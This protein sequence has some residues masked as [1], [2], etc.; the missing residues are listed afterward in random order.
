VER[1]QVRAVF[2]GLVQGVCFR[3][4]V[5]DHAQSLQLV[6]WVRNCD[7]SSV[8]MLAQGT[9]EQLTSLIDL[10]QQKPGYGRVDAVQTSFGPIVD[11]LSN[12]T[13]HR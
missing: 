4:A 1:V 3:A 10:I 8:E 12:F 2:S 9:Q 5:C 6:G 13:V 11:P 7:D